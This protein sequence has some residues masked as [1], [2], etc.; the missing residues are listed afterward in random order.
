MDADQARSP[1]PRRRVLLWSLAAGL[2]TCGLGSALVLA[3]QAVGPGR[4]TWLWFAPL[5][6]YLGHFWA[7]RMRFLLSAFLTLGPAFLLLGTGVA[8]SDGRLGTGVALILVALAALA[9]LGTTAAAGWV[10]NRWGHRHGGP[11]DDLFSNLP[12]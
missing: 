12:P 9:T 1:A 10:A 6:V 5:L 3:A 8:T 2:L 7:S 4:Q 11:L